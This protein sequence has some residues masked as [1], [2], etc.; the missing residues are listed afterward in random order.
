MS[1]SE[2]THGPGPLEGQRHVDFL[3]GAWYGLKASNCLCRWHSMMKESPYFLCTRLFYKH[4][5]LKRKDWHIILFSF[6]YRSN[7]SF[8]G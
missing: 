4:T 8:Q 2:R 6:L 3:K 7:Y 1:Y 5:C